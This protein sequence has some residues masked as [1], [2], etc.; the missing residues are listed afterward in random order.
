MHV[1]HN[2]HGD[3]GTPTTA[4]P[5]QVDAEHAATD[6]PYYGLYSQSE[7]E[8]L[9][10]VANTRHDQADH[11]GEQSQRAYLAMYIAQRVP[12]QVLYCRGVVDGVGQRYVSV[13]LP[14]MWSKGAR[15]A[16]G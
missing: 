5:R 4:L 9:C 10:E 11:A 14:G 2:S 15:H 3:A 7:L 1:V 16:R 12:G 8:R 13:H 6:G